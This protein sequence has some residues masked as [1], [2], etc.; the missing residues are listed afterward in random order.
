MLVHT[1]EQRRIRGADRKDHRLQGRWQDRCPAKTSAPAKAKTV[2]QNSGNSTADNK[3]ITN[4]LSSLGYRAGVSA[5]VPG[6]Y[7][8]DGANTYQ[9]AQTCF[10]GMKRDG[11][12]GS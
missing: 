12:L 9:K 5:G 11:D 4:L 1:E 3:A 8:R 7:L 2:T 10:P 6:T